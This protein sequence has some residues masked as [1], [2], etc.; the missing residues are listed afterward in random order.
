MK[1]IIAGSRSVMDPG[2]VAV[3]IHDSRFIVSEVVS[4]T[5]R[6]VDR[7]GEAYAERRGIPVRRFPAD[8]D[9][10]GRAAGM[11]RNAEMAKYADALVAVWDGR[12]KGTDNMITTMR[13][14]GKQ[15]HIHIPEPGE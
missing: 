15:V 12:S 5:A 8:W 3:A 1:V 6:G 4:G 14:L 10:F 2:Q 7:M 11:I 9:R 13:S